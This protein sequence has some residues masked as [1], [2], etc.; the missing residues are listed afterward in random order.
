VESLLTIVT[1]VKMGLLPKEAGKALVD[2]AFPSLT[3]EQ[4]NS[5]FDPI[6]PD[7]A[8]PPMVPQAPS[9]PGAKPAAPKAP[10]KPKV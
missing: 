10:K 9:I 1:N 6:E 7:K 5:I 3:R 8:P 4:I 2:A